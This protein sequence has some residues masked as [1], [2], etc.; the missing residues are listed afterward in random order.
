MKTGVKIVAS[1]IAA[2]G[3]TCALG[4]AALAEEQQDSLITPPETIVISVEGNDKIADIISR[5]K[6]EIFT[7]VVADDLTVGSVD[8][9]TAEW[10]INGEKVSFGVKV[11]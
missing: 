7:A 2:V 8:G 11:N 5:N 9:H 10:N 4:T 1:L 6:E 3:M